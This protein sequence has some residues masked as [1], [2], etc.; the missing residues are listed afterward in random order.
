M[1]FNK[2]Q[3][4]RL[5]SIA[6]IA[7]VLFFVG[8]FV[9]TRFITTERYS[10]SYSGQGND[11]GNIYVNPS[12]YQEDKGILGKRKQFSNMKRPYLNPIFKAV[13]S[14]ETE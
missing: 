10:S 13:I 11:S 7:V 4:L 1:T 14:N 9:L 5:I 2:K 12:L 3:I 8:K 6:L